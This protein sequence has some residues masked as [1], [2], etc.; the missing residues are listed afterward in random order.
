MLCHAEA[1]QM[2]ELWK[3]R[4]LIGMW[5]KCGQQTC[6]TQTQSGLAQWSS[7]VRKMHPQ[8]ASCMIWGP[9]P[10]TVVQP[11]SA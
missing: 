4:L 9:K 8:L 3:S 6:R 5:W 11:V 7:G 2:A 1:F 10:V